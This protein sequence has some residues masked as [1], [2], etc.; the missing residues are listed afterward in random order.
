MKGIRRSAAIA[1]AL[2]PLSGCMVGPK[3]KTPAAIVAPSFKEAPPASFAGYDG[4]KAGQPSDT[5][6]K[7]DWW[8]IFDDRN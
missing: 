6:M 5:K 7:G 4:W 1:M 8:T 3:Y 2:L